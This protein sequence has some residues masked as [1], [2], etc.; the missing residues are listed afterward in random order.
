MTGAGNA[1]KGRHVGRGGGDEHEARMTWAGGRKSGGR[2][3]LWL[4][5]GQ[6]RR[7]WLPG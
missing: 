5:F 3:G 4:G 2:P 7:A 1:S 6:R